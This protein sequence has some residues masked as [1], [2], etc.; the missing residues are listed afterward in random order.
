MALP[1]KQIPS[2]YYNTNLK[3]V[4]FIAYYFPP[5]GGGGVQRSINFARYLPSVGYLPVIITGPGRS[6]GRW[7]PIDESLLENIPLDIKIYRI[8]TP[9]P[10]NNNRISSKIHRWLYIPEQFSTWWIRSVIEISKKVIPDENI[11]LIYASMSLFESAD[12]AS[13]LSKMFQIPWVADLRDPWAL[14][15]MT[16]YTTLFHRKLELIK[17]KNLLQTASLVIMNTPESEKLLKNTFPL[18]VDK[19]VTTIINGYSENDF[20]NAVNNSQETGFKIVHSGSFHL[21]SGM[22][23]N[24]KKW[25]YKLLKGSRTQIDIS[26]RSHVILFHAL[27]RWFDK[28]PDVKKDIKII[29]V[30]NMTNEDKSFVKN[31][32]IHENVI[33]K[34][35][36]PYSENIKILKEA[37]L[38]FL[39]MHNLPYDVRSSVVPGKIYEYM[40]TG[41]PI[42]AAVPNGDAKDILSK[43]GTGFVCFP[44]DIENM[45]KI[46]SNIYGSWKNSKN[47]IIPNWEYIK[48]FERKN[49]VKKLGQ[50]LSKL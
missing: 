20:S 28:C 37:D 44:D 9:P 22:K 3:K 47:T 11:S 46:I 15:E 35:Y 2:P 21:D 39:P 23:Y 32:S 34:G 1:A 41:K 17:M 29:L 18:F 42:L 40:A 19:N 25:W 36:L 14:D 43:C 16:V 48:Q 12:A 45:I 4:L 26:T 31:S 38:L 7:T 5:I 10:A 6:D 33:L 49:Q 13:G 24:Q 30:G 8:S 27:E 50:E